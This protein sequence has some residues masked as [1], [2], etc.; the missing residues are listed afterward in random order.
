METG[1]GATGPGGSGRLLVRVTVTGLILGHTQ[2]RTRHLK[3]ARG[4]SVAPHK[5]AVAV[6]RQDIVAAGLE[7]EVG[8]DVHTICAAAGVHRATSPASA[9]S[10]PGVILCSRVANIRSPSS[11]ERLVGSEFVGLG[12]H[13]PA[14]GSSCRPNPALDSH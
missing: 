10:K 7:S 4:A 13:T 8:P 6:R 14:S 3:V 2:H 9:S 5:D 12:R 11:L 1:S